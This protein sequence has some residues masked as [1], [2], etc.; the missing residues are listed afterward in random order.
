[1]QTLLDDFFSKNTSQS[2]PHNRDQ[3]P[4]MSYATSLKHRSSQLLPVSDGEEPSLHFRWWYV[5]RLL[6]WHH[7]EGL[8]LPSLVIDWIFHQLQEKQLLEIWQLFLPIVYGFLEIV[9]LSQTYVRTLAGVALSIIRDPAP[10]GSDLVDNSR[11][12]YTAAALIEMLQYLIFAVPETFVTLD[13]F[14]LPFSV[15]SH[16]INDGNFVPKAIEAAEKIKNSSEDVVCTFRSK[17]LDAKYESLAFGRVISCIQKHAENL[18]KAVSPGYPGHCLAKAAQALDKSLVLGDIRGAY[19]FLFEDL[20]D[21]RS[22]E[23]WVAK[24]S[25]CLRLSLKWF[26]NV[27]SSLVYSVFFLC[28]WATSDFRDFRTAPPCDIKFTGKKDLSQVHI[29]VRLLK[30]KLRNMHISS[31]QRN[32]NTHH[33]VDYSAKCSSQHINWNNASKIKSSSKSM[34]QSICSSVIFESP[35][36]LH[37]IIVCWI[38]QHVV[39]KGVGFKCLHLFIVELILAGIFYPLAYVRQLIVSG[40]MDTSVNMVEL[41]RQKRHCQI[42]KQLSGNFVRHALEESEIIEGPLLIEALHVYL[43]ERRLILRGSFSENHINGSSRANNSTVNKKHCT[44][45]AKDGFSTVSI[46]Q[47]KTVPSNKISDKVEKDNTCVENLKTAIS[48]LLQLPKSLPNPNTTELGESQGSVKRLVRCYSKIDLMEATPG[49]EECRRAKKQKLSEERSSLDVEDTWWVKKGLKSLEPLK[50]DQPLKT[51]KQV[52]KSRHKTVRKTQ[53][54][55][56]LAASRIEGSQGA[57]TSHVCD[58]KVSCP[59]HRTAMDGDTAKSVDGIRTSQYQD[60]VSLGRAL[61]RLRFVEKKE[62]TVWLMT[63]IRQFIGDSEKSIGKVGQFGRPV[64]T[65]DD[66]SSIRWKLEEDELSAILYLMDVSDDLVPAIKFLLWLLPKVCS[67]SNSTIH[68]GRNVLMLARNVDNQVCN[69]GEAFLLSSLRRYENILAS[70]DLIPEAL[71]SVMDRAAAI[72]AS[73]GRVSGSGAL[74]F[75]RYLLKKY[76]NVVSVIE[77]EKNFKTTCDKRLASEFESG[78]RL[79]DGEF[80]LPLGVPAGIEDPDDY[81]RQKISGGR[82]PSRVASGMRDVVQRNVEDAFHYLFGKDRKLFA[83]GSPKGFSLEKWDNGYQIAQHIV[84]GL[85]DCIRQTGGAAQEGDPSL[86]TSAVSAIVGSVGPSLAKLP[87]FS[88]GNNHPNI[89]LATSSL[90]YAKCI[91]RMHITCLCLLKEALGER[92]SCVFDIALAIEA[93]NALAGVFAPSK[94]SRSQFQMSPETDDTSATMSNDVVN[95]SSKIVL[96]RTTKIASSVSALIVGAI[97]YGVTSL[98]RMVTILR[99]KEGLDVVQFVRNSRSNSNGNAR[100]T[101]A[102]KV[103]SSVEVHLHWFRLLVGNCRTICE[104]LVVDLLSE[105]SI[106]AF[107]RMQRTLPQRLVFPPAYSIFSFVI[108]RPFIT[109]ANVANR[110]DTNQ[111]Y[112]TLTMAINDAMKHLPFRDVC[113]RDSQGLYDLIAADTSDLEF[114]NLLELNGSD[115]RLN[116]TAF[117]PLCARLF[118]NAMVDCKMPQSIYTKDGGSCIS[119]HGESKIHFTDSESKLQDQLVDVLEALQPAKF[120]WQW[121]ELRLLLNE[122]ALIEKLQTHNVSLA[123]AIQL[124][125]PSSEKAA[126]SENENNFIQIL[127]TRLLV[128]PD[129]APLFSELVHLFGKSLEDSML[130]QAKWF[131]GGEDVLFGRKTIRQ[132]LINIAETK[133][134]SVKPHSLEPWGWCSPSTDPLTIKGGK[135]KVDS[136]SLEEGEVVEEGVNVKRSI[137]GFSQ[138]FDSEGS[139]IKQQHGTERAFLELILPCIDQSSNESRYSFA[140]GLIKQ[141]SYI[142]QQIAV[143]T[144]GPG[145]PAASMPVTEGQTNKGN[146]RKT[147]KGG[148]L[149][150][151]RRPTSSTDSSPPSP[152]ALRASMSLRIQLLMRFLPIL[153]TDGEPSVRNMRRTLASVTLRLLGSRI[154]LEDANILVNAT[155]SSLSKKDAES[156]SKV[157]YAAFVDSSVEGLFERLLL[158][159]HGLLSSSPPSWLR[160]KPVSKTTTNEPTRDLSGVDRELLETLQV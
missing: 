88:A 62:I 57:S 114:A 42:L 43:N 17:G 55:A 65:M 29:A 122:L 113:L 144:C 115:M 6:Q 156:P 71:S 151:A 69:V 136:L 101:G 63:V 112:Q 1:M 154:V 11:R 45:S 78:G 25:P 21:G 79:V 125:L 149:G 7:T 152:A 48:V 105:P 118:L 91:L 94:A 40:I 8:L 19:T 153:C 22:S 36:P 139:T 77:W 143:V 72:I 102:I 16:T 157:A 107:S 129:A 14:P 38:D 135:R 76:S 50:V 106:V 148:S 10:G 89:S 119:G 67:S 116:S 142:E 46:D 159:L 20:Y 158:M 52:T 4:Q 86:V 155:H 33:G 147:I 84:I 37:D 54:L 56:Q 39:H 70:A 30:M 128:R 53:S 49:C 68:S 160:L 95:S 64:T 41:E 120:H 99:L 28:E 124:S 44:S 26:V 74:A 66:R 24:I 140:S 59:H 9:V 121:V 137:K 73:N 133:G 127:F 96:A 75:A 131:L 117:V 126:A 82:L 34:N 145:N 61:K 13:C 83:A 85:I 108:W 15:V 5:V 47:Q 100:S 12:A 18:T 123:D 2:T 109:S 60:I 103:D 98:E 111:L 110:E 104:G 3:S 51:T 58:I 32:E 141:L 93:S 90:N 130:L 23:G 92:Q 132:R 81:F 150:L 31:R 97:I 87:D 80:G 134:F 138:V 146:S 35:G 27:N